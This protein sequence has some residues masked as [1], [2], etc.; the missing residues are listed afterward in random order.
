MSAKQ[1]AVGVSAVAVTVWGS[2]HHVA[3]ASARSP[4]CDDQGRNWPAYGAVVPSADSPAGSAVSNLLPPQRQ[5]GYVKRSSL[6]PTP[7]PYATTYIADTDYRLY[8]H[9]PGAKSPTA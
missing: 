6:T 8:G 3:P 1:W 2:P 7:R 9:A 4:G 5:H